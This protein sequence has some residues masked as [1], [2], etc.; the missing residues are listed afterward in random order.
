MTID[1]KTDRICTATEWRDFFLTFLDPLTA[2]PC[3]GANRPTGFVSN[4]TVPA[5]FLTGTDREAEDGFAL[6]LAWAAC[7][8]ELFFGSYMGTFPA[9]ALIVQMS[10]NSIPAL[11]GSKNHVLS[12]P[13][14]AGKTK[15]KMAAVYFQNNIQTFIKPYPSIADP[16]QKRHRICAD[17]FRTARR[18]TRQCGEQAAKTYLFWGGSAIK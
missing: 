1:T 5:V 3:W 10:M 7:W 4:F 6:G 13:P 14:S 16:L 8:A 11:N 18:A 15:R 12:S 9:C 2:R 17:T